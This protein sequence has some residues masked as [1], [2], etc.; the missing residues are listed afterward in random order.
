M[1][2]LNHLNFITAVET[3][4]DMIVTGCADKSIILWD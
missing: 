4:K 3:S 1:F 2:K